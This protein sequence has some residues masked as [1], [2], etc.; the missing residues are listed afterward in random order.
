[1]RPLRRKERQRRNL[2]CRASSAE[3]CLERREP[4]SGPFHNFS[5]GR[6]LWF[7]PLRSPPRR[8]L[9]QPQI[10]WSSDRST[11]FACDFPPVDFLSSD[12][13]GGNPDAT[14]QRDRK[15][16]KTG[17]LTPGGKRRSVRAELRR[18]Q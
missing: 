2:P 11:T 14:W 4:L 8:R 16:L 1:M 9:V 3:C 7:G 18:V 10:R 6:H 15:W 13:R 12:P 5:I 17:A